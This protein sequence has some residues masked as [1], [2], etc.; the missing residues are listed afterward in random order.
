MDGGLK[1]VTTMYKNSSRNVTLILISIKFST[2]TT[3]LIIGPTIRFESNNL[4]RADQVQKED[5]IRKVHQF[6]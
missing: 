3:V 2:T 4:D 1:F 5:D 6:L